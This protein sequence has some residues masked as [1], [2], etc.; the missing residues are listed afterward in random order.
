VVH[1]VVVLLL[2]LVVL[3]LYLVLVVEVL[4]PLFQEQLV[5]SHNYL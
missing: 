4:R 5:H 3:P 1:Q 2:P